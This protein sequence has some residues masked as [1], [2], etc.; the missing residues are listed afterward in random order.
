MSL[1]RHVPGFSVRSSQDIILNSTLLSKY[2]HLWLQKK[3]K[4]ALAIIPNLSLQNYLFK[5]LR[6]SSEWYEEQCWES[7]SWQ[8]YGYFSKSN[9]L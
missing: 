8:H 2:G 4:M 5:G 6:E 3:N 9:R 1:P 7:L